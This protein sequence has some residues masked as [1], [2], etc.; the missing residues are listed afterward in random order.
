MLELM[1]ERGVSKGELSRRTGLAWTT[2]SRA[3]SGDRIGQFD[4]WIKMC[5]A[6]GVSIDEVVGCS[7]TERK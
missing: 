4:T 6:I 3:L 5:E 1:R 2:V 7:T